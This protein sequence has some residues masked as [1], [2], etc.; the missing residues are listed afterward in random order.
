LFLLFKDNHEEAKTAVTNGSTKEM[1]GMTM[2]GAKSSFSTGCMRFP[3][4]LIT[5]G[6]GYLG[7]SLV[8]LLL[9]KGY[10]VI[11][12]D[13]MLWGITG[14]LPCVGS[15]LLKI[16]NG[17]ILDVQHLSQC[18]S[19]CNA[20]IHLAAIVGYPAC[21]KDPELAREVNEQGTK[22]VVG[23]LRRGQALVYAST[24]SCY[25]AIPNGLCTEETSISP[26]TL[27]GSSKAEGEKAVMKTSSSVSLRLATV[28]G[29]SP[30]LRLDLLVNDLTHKAITMKHFDLYQGEFRRTFLHVKDAANAFVFA[31][32][33]YEAMKG[34]VFNVGDE[35]MNMSKAEVAEWIEK[36]IPEC[37]ITKSDSGEDKDKRNYEVSYRKIRELG[38]QAT[39]SVEEGIE[40]LLKVLPYVTQEEATKARNV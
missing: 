33:N 34:Q 14:L 1:N 11:V 40:E 12:Y 9:Q 39:I 18:M 22:N 5:G 37:T 16:V 38:F 20:V 4:V 15:R 6:A 3:K 2:N 26:L 13:Q 35:H 30:R 19:Q 17:N 8:P 31:L 10:E 21:E 32:E 23:C 28:F 36:S 29:V 24:G 25:G 27:Y 7:T